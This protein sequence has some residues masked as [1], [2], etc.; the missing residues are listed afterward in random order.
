VENKSLQIKLLLDFLNKIHA[1]FIILLCHQ[2]SDPD[3]ICSAYA[4]S[5]LL[6]RL[7]PKLEIEVA[8]AEGP[9]KI[10]ARILQ[11]INMDLSENPRFKD[12]D[13]FILLD[14]NNLQQLG[15]WKEEIEK[16]NKAV[17]VIDHHVKHPETEKIARLSIINEAS[18]TCEIVYR[19]FKEAEIKPRKDEAL[20]M[21]LGISY[22][23]RH[24]ALAGS[25]VFRIAVELIDAGVDAKEALGM[26][27]NEVDFSEHIARLK[28]ANR[29]NINVVEGR[30]IV[31]SHVNSYEASAARALVEIGADVAVVGGEREGEISISL[32]AKEEFYKT[33]HIHLGQ[34]IANPV[35]EFLKGMGG[36]HSISAGVNGR[37]NLDAAL[38]FCL[39]LLTEK[40]K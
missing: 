24:F 33:T 30:I 38:K 34:D 28:A 17:I 8:A 19:L 37:G 29:A 15:S 21:F 12:A 4:F 14:T 36:G 23:S 27:S 16:L 39:K 6:K 32:R 5:R 9:S 26:L 25:E 20:A 13:A 22:D 18:S 31:F 11:T 7:K 2:N 10:S 3:A 35:G 1:S 40:L